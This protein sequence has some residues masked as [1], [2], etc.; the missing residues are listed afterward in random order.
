[1][2]ASNNEYRRYEV[3]SPEEPKYKVDVH[4]LKGRFV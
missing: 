3:S 2:M 1:M 4:P